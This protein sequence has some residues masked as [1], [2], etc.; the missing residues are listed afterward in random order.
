MQPSRRYRVNSKQ[1]EIG[2]KH[3][4]EHTDNPARARRIA[5]D[6]L[7]EHPEY[8]KVLPIAEKM[9]TAREKNIRP[10]KRKKREPDGPFFD[11][12]LRRTGL[13]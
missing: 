7:Q 8:Y 10:I 13:F 11:P 1:L 2:T 9:M 12:S 3:E 5:R 6:H 4:M